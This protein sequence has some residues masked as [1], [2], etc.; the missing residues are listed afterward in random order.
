MANYD[1]AAGD[2]KQVQGKLTGDETR[3]AEGKAQETEG[4]L[5]QAW[6][7]VEDGAED[8]KDRITGS[9]DK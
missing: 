1:E 3:E 4:E 9:D 8:I 7:K 6:D 2:A 5:E